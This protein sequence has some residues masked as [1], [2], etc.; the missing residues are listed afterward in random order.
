MVLMKLESGRFE[1]KKQL[2]WAND[3]F[4]T[5]TGKLKR[6]EAMKD[7][8]VVDYIFEVEDQETSVRCKVKKTTGN[9]KW[10]TLDFPVEETNGSRFGKCTCGAP[11]VLGVPCEHMVAAMK[12]GQIQG[13]NADNMMPYWWTTEQMRLQYPVDIVVQADMD[14]AALKAEG[15]PEDTIRYCPSL[16]APN[17]AG[18]PKLNARIR[19]VLEQRSRR[20]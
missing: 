6:D 18:R 8:N 15:Q 13:L 11:N 20:S 2:A 5:P 9:S 12:S 1:R 4:L 19:G 7:I 14:M 16:A 3:N 10:V 17:K